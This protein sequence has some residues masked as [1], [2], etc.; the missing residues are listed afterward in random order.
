[1]IRLV[2]SNM[3]LF[4]IKWLWDF[5]KAPLKRKYPKNIANFLSFLTPKQNHLKNSFITGIL[6]W[7]TLSAGAQDLHFSQWHASD[8]YLNPAFTGAYY[9]PRVVL[10]FRDQWPDLPQ[11]YLS[12]RAAFDGYLDAIHSGVGAYIWQDDQGEGILKGTHMGAQYMYQARFSG[13]WALNMG[14]QFEYAQ[15]RLNWNDL[16][17]YDQID[18]LFGFNDALGNPNATG[19][20]V[21]PSLTTGYG[22]FSAGLLFYSTK[23]FAGCSFNHIT[24]PTISFYNNAASSLPTGISFQAGALLGN[25]KKK[26]ALMLNPFLLY[27]YQGHFQQ[28][29]GGFYLKK[30]MLLG[31]MFF[32]H[33]TSTFSDVVLCAG[34]SKGLF[35][36]AYSYDISVGDLAGLS[37]GAHEVSLI[38]TFKENEN[39]AK[40]TSQKSMLGCPSLL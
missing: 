26:D 3:Q 39:R 19:E 5:L 29:E 36:F 2:G 4:F 37:G 38:F 21:P 34:V 30:G 11:T 14:T 17:F 7:T 1:M 22:D 10:N 35:K 33:N 25:E 6:L 40:R 13:N 23:V 16:K 20:A 15:Y 31:G 27:S 18:L 32:K 12:Y 24:N 8:N 9:Q 28:I